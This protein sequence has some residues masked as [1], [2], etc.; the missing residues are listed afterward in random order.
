ML[1]KQ[2]QMKQKGAKALELAVWIDDH[3]ADG[4]DLKEATREL[5]KVLREL[6]D[7]LGNQSSN[8]WLYATVGILFLGRVLKYTTGL[9]IEPGIIKQGLAML[10]PKNKAPKKKKS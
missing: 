9:D 5:V 7:D 10:K 8:W 2:A 1:E 6:N 3:T 4:D